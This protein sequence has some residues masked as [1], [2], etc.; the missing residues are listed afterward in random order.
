M[1][2]FLV[3]VVAVLI[4]GT[5]AAA[6]TRLKHADLFIS[7]FGGDSLPSTVIF[8]H[9]GPGFNAINFERGAAPLLS[10]VTRVI[11]YD[12]FGCGRSGPDSSAR[13]SFSAAIADLDEVIRLSMKRRSGARPLLVGHSFGGNLA[14]EYLDR[15]PGRVSGVVLVCTPISYPVALLALAQRA[16][17]S[18]SHFGNTQAVALV[19]QSLQLDPGGEDFASRIFFAGLQSGAYFPRHMTAEGRAAL[20]ESMS[21]ATDPAVASPRQH[22]FQGFIRSESYTLLD[23][24][25]ILTKHSDRIYAIYGDEDWTLTPSFRR[26]ISAR[27]PSGRF[28]VIPNAGHFVFLDGRSTFVRLV[29]KIASRSTP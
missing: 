22:E 11:S 19:D 23:Q 18:Y 13:A 15:H 6:Q 21:P 26:R 16:K 24:A 25:H 29:G 14:L 28:H 20:A 8:L 3:W 7:S 9:G 1:K 5:S 17:R 12:R 4:F 27:L 10:K 2:A